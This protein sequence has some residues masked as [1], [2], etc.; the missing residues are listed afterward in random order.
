MSLPKDST[1]LKNKALWTTPN[2]EGWMK[3]SGA[4]NK[5]MKRRYFVLQ[6]QHLF[7]FKKKGAQPLNSI[8]IV[9]CFVEPTTGDGTEF[10]LRSLH[11]DRIFRFKT[12]NVEARGDWIEA[13]ST[14]ISNVCAPITA[15][16]EVQHNFHV[17]FDPDEGYVVCLRFINIKKLKE[18]AN[19]TKQKGLPEDWKALLLSSSLSTEE[20]LQNQ[21][22]VLGALNTQ[23]NFMKDT[24]NPRLSVDLPETGPEALTLSM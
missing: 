1:I 10:S 17:S 6:G 19:N 22:A 9:D 2:H 24:N 12:D 11:F 14:A 18:K 15:P 20:V 16:Q 7:Y 21:D 13:I 23:M 5:A 3:K 8:S 4:V